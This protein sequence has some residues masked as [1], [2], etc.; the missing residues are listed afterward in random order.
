[1]C[2]IICKLFSTRVERKFRS[3]CVVS[4]VFSFQSGS[5]FPNLLLFLAQIFK[6]PGAAKMASPNAP[7]RKKCLGKQHD[8]DKSLALKSENW[9]QAN[10]CCFFPSPPGRG[11]CPRVHASWVFP[12]QATWPLQQ[13]GDDPNR[14]VGDISRR[15]AETQMNVGWWPNLSDGRLLWGSSFTRTNGIFMNAT[16]AGWPHVGKGHVTRHKLV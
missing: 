16:L 6:E 15:G 9:R 12:R 7:Q 10:T 8:D 1:M 14:R 2:I 4:N 11:D 13:L 5:F 3:G